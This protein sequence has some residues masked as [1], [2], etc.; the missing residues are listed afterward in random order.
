VWENKWNDCLLL[1]RRGKILYSVLNLTC[2]S[3]H[4]SYDCQLHCANNDAWDSGGRETLNVPM[5]QQSDVFFPYEG[6]CK[7]L[8][9]GGG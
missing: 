3:E 8:M 7:S 4:T 2:H 6:C 9:S 1:Y 5:M